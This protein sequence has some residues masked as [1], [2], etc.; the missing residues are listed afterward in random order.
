MLL[1]EVD[2]GDHLTPIL[3]VNNIQPY[4]LDDTYYYMHHAI[5]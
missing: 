1:K 5:Y 2:K 4:W 3:K